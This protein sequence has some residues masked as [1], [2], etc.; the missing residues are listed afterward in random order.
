MCRAPR[1]HFRQRSRG[2]DASSRSYGPG[3]RYGD[4]DADV[5]VSFGR[6]ERKGAQGR[7]G[8]AAGALHTALKA[9]CPLSRV[10]REKTLRVSD[11]NCYT[12]LL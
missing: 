7:G 12:T 8:W 10:L 3:P 1:G 2:E 11:K 9:S 6:L 5:S 4:V